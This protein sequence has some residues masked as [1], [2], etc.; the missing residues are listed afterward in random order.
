MHAYPH[1]DT[2][3]YTTMHFHAA[4]QA[5]MRRRGITR[6]EMV[7][8]RRRGVR[9]HLASLR[10]APSKALRHGFLYSFSICSTHATRDALRE[11]AA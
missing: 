6:G 8:G 3:T 10:L 11:A 7:K 2:C 9:A 1:N 4:R 5:L